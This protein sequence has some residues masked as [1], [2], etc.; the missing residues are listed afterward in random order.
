MKTQVGNCRFMGGIAEGT[1]REVAVKDDVCMVTMK[2]HGVLT[3]EF[4]TRTG[5][6]EFTADDVL[7]ESLTKARVVG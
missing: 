5:F 4:Y 1:V 7:A 3:T 6:R 2:V